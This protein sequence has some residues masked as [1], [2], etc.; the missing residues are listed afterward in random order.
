MTLAFVRRSLLGAFAAM[1]LAACA[2]GGANSAALHQLS[3][4]DYRL[5]TGDQLR[6]TIFGEADLSGEYVITDQGAV[7]FPLVGE[8]PAAG[9]TV[10][11]FSADLDARLRQGY[12]RQPNL[13]VEV[14][15]F[16][17]FYILGEVTQP[18]TYPYSANLT[19][20]NAV[21]TA[22]GFSYRADQRRVYIK[23]A[24]QTEERAY[25]LTTSTPVLPGDTIR[26]GE[27]HF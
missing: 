17:P 25:R 14:L 9:K 10:S 22:K 3:A 20:M 7:S 24:D 12:V 26:I 15:N 23:H 4:V 5:G 16:R 27:R 13:A 18:G 2:G 19:V 1:L 6:V 11:E 21:A 8:V